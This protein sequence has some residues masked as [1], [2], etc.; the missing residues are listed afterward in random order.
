MLLSEDEQVSQAYKNG[1]LGSVPIDWE[2]TPF[3][4]LFVSF[5]EY[6]N[7]LDRFPLYSLTIEV[8]LRKRNVM[9]VVIL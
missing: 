2:K 4:E 8:L 6:T 9:N 7:D 1:P 5:I 3:S